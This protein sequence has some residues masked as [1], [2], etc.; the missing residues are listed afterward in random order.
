VSLS[1]EEFGA[2]FQRFMEWAARSARQDEPVFAKKLREHFDAEP[3]ELPVTR[4]ELAPYDRPNLQVALDSYLGQAGRHAELLGFTGHHA[5]GISLS[6]LLQRRHAMI[7]PDPGPVERTLV[8]LEEGRTLSCVTTGLFLVSD[9]RTRLAL[10]VARD[11]RG[12]ASQVEVM[13]HNPETGE[14]F[15]TELRRLMGK[16]NVYRGKVI[17]LATEHAPVGAPATEVTFH[18]R[19]RTPRGRIV[20][21]DGTLERIELHTT[22]FAR[23]TGA[24]RA[25]GRHIRRGLLLHGAPGTGKTLTSSYLAGALKDRTVIILTGAGLGLI[26]PSCTLARNLEPSMVV[27]EDVDLVA[28]ERTMMGTTATALLFQLLNEMDGIGE[29]ADVIFL[30]TTNRADLLEPALASRPGRVDQAVELPLP[31]ANG[32]ERLLDL[33]CEGLEVRLEDRRAVVEATDGASPAF[34]RELVRKAALYAAAGGAPEVMDEHFAEGLRQ[35]E[36]GGRLTRSILGAGH[37]APPAQD[38]GWPRAVDGEGT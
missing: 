11:Q 34:L 26:G 38:V 12:V 29:D 18:S 33:F 4:E 24:L 17:S 19:P 10:L 30:M 22:D 16:L 2:S 27:L 31:D 7:A 37:G 8:P 32:R 20:L 35:L 36:E 28:Q 9:G 14:G 1:P 23:H 21:P 3:S 15:L 25:V 13:A 6:M 5:V